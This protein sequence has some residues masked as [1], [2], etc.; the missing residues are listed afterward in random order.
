MTVDHDLDIRRQE[1]ATWFARLSQRRVSAEDVRAFSIWRRDT[2]NA[3]A[4]D[5]VET[6]WKASNALAQDPDIAALTADALTSAPSALRSRAAA[7]G[8]RKTLAGFALALAVAILMGVWALQRPETYSTRTGEQRMIVLTDGSRVMLD[9]DTVIRVRLE[10]HL[11]TISLDRGQAFFQVSGDPQRPFIVT[12]GD[13]RVTAIG[14]RFDVRR[15]GDGARIT[16]IEG[17]VAVE[18]PDTEPK[19]RLRPGEQISTN[20]ARPIVAKVDAE[21]VTSWTTGRLIFE[22]T[23]VRAAV[24]EVNRYSDRK[25]ELQAVTIA[26]IP[27]SGA[28]DTGDVE[29]FAA[30][31]TDLYPVSADPQADRIVIRPNPG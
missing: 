9:T 16:L 5:R 2:R 1:A 30:A 14:T 22:G 25:I 15:T 21:R 19:W 29:G 17:R 12:S 27:V 20:A 7:Y 11:R 23:P 4:Y 6:L 13:T 8:L 18:G 28:F 3:A 26:D 24:A 10:R 31:L